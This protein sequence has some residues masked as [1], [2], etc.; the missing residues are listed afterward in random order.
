[1]AAFEEK[2]QKYAE[3]AVK[4]GVNIQKG[5]TLVI[6]ASISAVDFVRKI[7]R[8]AY[9]NGANQ[10]YIEWNDEKL[11]RLECELA[12][13]E[14]LTNIPMWKIK[15]YE[16]MAEEGAAFLYVLSPY[17]DN[18]E[19][20]DPDRIN[21]AAN[22]VSE[23]SRH[24]M[25]GLISMQTAW[26][27]VAIPTVQWAKKVFPRLE[28]KEGIKKL[29]ES[30]FYVTRIDC[31]NPVT[32]WKE[33]L[34]GLNEK[35]E[36]LNNKSFRFL[37]FKGP[38]TNLTIELPKNHLWVNGLNRNAKGTP[39]IC[40]LPTE[41]VYTTPLKTGVNGTVQ[42]TKPLVYDGQ[43]IDGFTLTF[44]KGRII[45]FSAKSG[46]EQLK[47]MI[48]TDEGTR[49]IGEVALV[50]HHSP[51]SISKLIYYHTLFDE[52]AAC[53]IAIGH[54]YTTGLK[55][56]GMMTTEEREENNIN[57]SLI[58]IDVMIGQE[59]LQVDGEREDGEIEP[60]FIQGNWTEYYK[61]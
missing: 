51:I 38:G 39:F 4:V 47:Q 24:F 25:E 60:I 52:N 7:S 26:S 18:M 48:S 54:A 49:Y 19:G 55:E 61:G 1:M 16:K 13:E 43:L 20:I 31:N 6:F 15:G 11:Q 37:H 27:V 33:H 42:I 21:L 10:V 22:A 56:G 3:L 50:P 35:T 23:A 8:T 5:Q 57:S 34:N 17:I 41:E 12:S 44:E 59:Q 40:N 32:A 36:L 29:W 2:I 9:K 28:S 46:Y 58:H 53:H 30:I 45:D 14:A